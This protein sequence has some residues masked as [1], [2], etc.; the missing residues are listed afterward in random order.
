MPGG[1]LL[2][3]THAARAARVCAVVTE[4]QMIEAEEGWKMP[5]A[6]LCRRQGAGGDV[7]VARLPGQHREHTEPVGVAQGRSL[8]ARRR[9]GPG[10]A[11]VVGQQEGQ[12]EPWEIKRAVVTAPEQGLHPPAVW[13][14]GCCQLISL[15][16]PPAHSPQPQ[17]GALKLLP[18]LLRTELWAEAGSGQATRR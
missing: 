8:A 9:K 6:S 11:G 3:N 15:P 10:P 5:H 17:G 14:R 16:P 7:G 13:G 2:P 4:A 12:R 18:S 1:L